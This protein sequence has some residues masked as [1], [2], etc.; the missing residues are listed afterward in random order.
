MWRGVCFSAASFSP[1]LGR[2]VGLRDIKCAAW[3][4]ARLGQMG[5]W[6]GRWPQAQISKG[7]GPA[8]TPPPP[9]PATL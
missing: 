4:C 1:G 2:V 6:R 5:A 8:P 7:S 9:Q 3:G